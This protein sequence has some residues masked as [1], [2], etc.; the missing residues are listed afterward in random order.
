MYVSYENIA[1]YTIYRSACDSFF[2]FHASY[3]FSWYW[4]NNQPTGL[5][6][7]VIR[8]VIHVV[9][10]LLNNITKKKLAERAKVGHG[11]L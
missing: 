10:S 1:A 6:N 2:L 5:T 4:Y 11:S 8:N 7:K 3:S 9:G